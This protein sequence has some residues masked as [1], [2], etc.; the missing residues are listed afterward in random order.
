MQRRGRPGYGD[1][2]SPREREVA[3]LAASGLTNKEIAE[4]LFVSIKTVESHLHVA[5]RK[6]GL[7]TRTDLRSFF[8]VNE[9]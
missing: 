9:R 4:K 7:R 2:L 8:R 6:L 3:E 1:T 5:L